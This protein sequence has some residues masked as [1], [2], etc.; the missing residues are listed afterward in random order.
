LMT[1]NGRKNET[2]KRWLGAHGSL[3]LASH[4]SPNRVKRLDAPSC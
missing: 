4:V 2:A 3:S 1:E